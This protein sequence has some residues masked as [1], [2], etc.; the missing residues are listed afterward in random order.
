VVGE[1]DRVTPP[2]LSE[3]IVARLHGVRLARIAGAGHISNIECPEE[4]NQIVLEFLTS[5]ER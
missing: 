1:Q 4:F 3:E 2:P 5:V